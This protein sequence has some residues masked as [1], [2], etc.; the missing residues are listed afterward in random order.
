VIELRLVVAALNQLPY[1]TYTGWDWQG[2]LVDFFNKK[3]QNSM[4]LPPKLHRQKTRAVDKWLAY[5]NLTDA[6][7]EWIDEI[8]DTW[9]NTQNHLRGFKQFKAALDGIV[10]MDDD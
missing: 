9:A 7:M 1:G 8:R 3:H 5:K 2:K 4:C 10:D 6:E